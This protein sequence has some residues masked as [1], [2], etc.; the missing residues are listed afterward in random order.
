MDCKKF[1]KDIRGLDKEMRSWDTYLG[2]EGVVKNMITSLRAVAELQNPAIRDRH[3]QQLMRATGVSTP[4][5]TFLSL[6]I[7]QFI[8]FSATFNKYLFNRFYNLFFST[9]QF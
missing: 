4:S 8:Y 6:Y 9:L 7:P 3:W 5:F 2:L 1:A